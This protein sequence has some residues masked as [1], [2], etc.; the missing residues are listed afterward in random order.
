MSLN[1]LNSLNSLDDV[2]GD[3]SLIGKTM[4]IFTLGKSSYTADTAGTKSVSLEHG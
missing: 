1:S 3:F 4:P 2:L